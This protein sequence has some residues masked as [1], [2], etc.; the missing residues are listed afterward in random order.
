MD[1]VFVNL[2]DSSEATV[3]MYDIHGQVVDTIFKGPLPAGRQKIK[4]DT[5]KFPAA[6]VFFYT[7]TAGDFRETKKFVFMR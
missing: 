5:S 1:A 6:G 3:V 4:L 7:V 2:P